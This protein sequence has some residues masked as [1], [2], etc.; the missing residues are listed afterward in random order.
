MANTRCSKHIS[1]FRGPG[2]GGP[3]PFTRSSKFGRCS[4]ADFVVQSLVELPRI[5]WQHFDVNPSAEGRSGTVGNRLG[6]SSRSG[7]V[8]LSCLVSCWHRGCWKVRWCSSGRT[9][10]DLAPTPGVRDVAFMLAT[11]GM[12]SITPS[13]SNLLG[14]ILQ[15][16]Y[17]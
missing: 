13:R 8:V 1:K 5:L 9:F 6:N 2:R 14:E 10:S 16:Q 3:W 12:P 15:R 7:R 4:G 17:Y 11:V